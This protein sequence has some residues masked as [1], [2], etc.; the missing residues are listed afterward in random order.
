MN[1]EARL[2]RAHV[3]LQAAPERA[4]DRRFALLAR[5]GAYEVRLVEPAARSGT[6]RFE[7]WL[8]LFNHLQKISV[9]SAGAPDL[10]EAVTLA[11][12][13]IAQARE[14]GQK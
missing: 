3:E 14:L 6:S 12:E 13:L 7:F 5:Y 4:D 9:D 8:E 10:E 1:L 2:I 11:E